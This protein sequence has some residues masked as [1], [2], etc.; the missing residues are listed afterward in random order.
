MSG[1][2]LQLPGRTGRVRAWRFQSPERGHSE[3]DKAWGEAVGS[4]A[5][6]QGRHWREAGWCGVACPWEDTGTG[7]GRGSM[8]WSPWRRPLGTGSRDD[9]RLL[10]QSQGHG[11][12]IP[13]LQRS[14]SRSRR[15]LQRTGSWGS[16]GWPS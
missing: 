6:V 11:T 9:G 12:S 14:K 13:V 10:E 2:S 8:G 1:V 7:P 15:L 5:G 16:R 4:R 3:A